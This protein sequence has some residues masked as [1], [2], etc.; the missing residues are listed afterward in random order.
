MPD[1]AALK[2]LIV[3]HYFKVFRC[4]A[5]QDIYQLFIQRWLE[6]LFM[7]CNLKH[8]VNFEPSVPVL[9]HLSP[10]A[11]AILI[12]PNYY[13][14]PQYTPPYMSVFPYSPYRIV[15]EHKDEFCQNSLEFLHLYLDITDIRLVG[16][17]QM[18]YK[19]HEIIADLQK[20]YPDI[21]LY[22]SKSFNSFKRVATTGVDPRSLKSQPQCSTWP[23][24][25]S[26]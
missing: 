17:Y 6:L 19:E 22:G 9:R 10:S 1:F 25:V 8:F 7:Y 18:S 3:E 11:T 12:T 2:L 14:R 20:K 23:D 15:F 24:S 13:M 5:K 21:V 16:F 26:Q 4:Y